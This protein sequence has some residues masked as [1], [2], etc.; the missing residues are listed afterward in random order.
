M[1]LWMSC[2]A[3]ADLVTVPV[4]ENKIYLLLGR[5]QTYM[6]YYP[7]YS[8]QFGHIYDQDDFIITYE[9]DHRG[10][11]ISEDGMLHIAAD[12]E[13]G[14]ISIIVTYA[15]KPWPADKRV[16]EYHTS[17]YLTDAPTKL[18]VSSE[19]VCMTIRSRSQTVRV[20]IP[21]GMSLIESYTYDDS[22]LNV[23]LYK[24]DPSTYSHYLSIDPVKVGESDIILRAP[25][26]LIKYIRVVVTEYPSKVELS[27][28]SYQ[29]KVGETIDL[30][31][32]LGNG[33]YGVAA[34][35]LTMR[36]K[37]NGAYIS[38]SSFR[39]DE[40]HFHAARAGVFDVEIDC[41]GHQD[42]ARIQVY[43][44]AACA[45]IRLPAGVVG[46]GEVGTPI[47]LRDRA[48][49][50]IFR[51][52]SISEGCELYS[53]NGSWWVKASK[54]GAFTV[55]VKNPD[56]ST[57]AETF[58]AVAKPTRLTLN[59][60]ELTMQIGE[61]AQLIPTFDVPGDFVCEYTIIDQDSKRQYGL[62]CITV[63]EDGT[64]RAQG[65]GKAQVE[66][67]YGSL[68][69][70]CDVVVEEGPKQIDFVLTES[71]LGVGR[72]TQVTVQDKTG[73]VYPATFSSRY[74]AGTVTPDGQITGLQRG[75]FTLTAQLADGRCL[76]KGIL[77][78]V[79]PKWLS[80]NSLVMEMDDTYSFSHVAT[81]LGDVSSDEV[82]LEIADPGVARLVN[83]SIVPVSPGK[84]TATITSK[85][86][87]AAVTF[88]I[89]VLDDS[90]LYAGSTYMHV[91]YGFMAYLPVVTNS[92]G[93]EVKVTWKITQE[94]SGAGNPNS[95]AFLLE[96]NTI[97]CLWPEGSCILTGTASNKSTVKVTVHGYRMPERISL[98]PAVVELA[99][100]E[101]MKLTVQWEDDT[102]QVKTVYWIA[103][104]E[105]I[106]SYDENS[107]SL[108]NTITARN[109]G[110]AQ[111]MALLDNGAYA[112]CDVT[113]YD[114]HARIPGD[115]NED[116]VVDL[117]DALLVMQHE[118]GWPVSINGYAADVDA[119]GKLDL[120]DALLLLQYGAG[121]NVELRQY[122]PET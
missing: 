106:F 119:D 69:A 63:D 110:T 61:T 53:S 100:G 50:S 24:N 109:A 114:P 78:H 38:D 99:R 22:F 97:A 20:N 88:L 95:S 5:E 77:V 28:D 3:N 62:T 19:L 92:S 94:T 71:P 48:G 79:Y 52:A 102:A 10:V 11:T 121:L 108:S 117:R 40:Y 59:T 30:G 18:E 103:E 32:D 84:T 36:V 44:D 33:P 7:D 57:C 87:D 67:K 43:D 8:Y 66:V 91:P 51:P 41:G 60:R 4:K 15:Y 116:G 104:D 42:T 45:E 72:T 29:C 12:A 56:G 118:A 73:K 26:N 96:D 98:T 120:A 101:E 58:E 34:S 105:T 74:D 39:T 70:K 31:I 16:N 90:V 54:A 111:I 93:K 17:I 122:V 65:P 68:L 23:Q 113:V 81:D 89:E 86:T 80:F 14:R 64:V 9:T 27:S 47:V 37:E 107:T 35:R 85:Y 6:P 49:K 82:T 25:N 115:A 1:L 2:A 112:I 55:T 76:E 46:V 13:R 21:S 83:R 75:A